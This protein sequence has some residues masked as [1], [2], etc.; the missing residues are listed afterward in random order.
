MNKSNKGGAK[1]TTTSA[2]K[3]PT[4]NNE[5][6]K[7][8]KGSGVPSEGNKTTTQN[9]NEKR[10]CA[11]VQA[12]YK[13]T[14][15]KA[16]PNK[17]SINNK[18]NKSNGNGGK[19]PAKKSKKKVDKLDL[20]L[21]EFKSQ[22][23]EKE[24]APN[25][26]CAG[27]DEAEQVPTEEKNKIDFDE[28]EI[29]VIKKN[30]TLKEH[31]ME[32]Q[33]NSHIRLLKNWPQVEMSIQTN[34]PTVPIEMVYQGKDYPIGEIQNYKHVLSGK[35]LQ[36]KKELEK[37]SLDYYEDLR[38][39]A[40]CHRQVRKYIQAYVQPGRKM[41]DI[42][43]ETEKKTKELILSHKLNCGWGFPTGCSLNH[44][45]AHYTPNYGDETVLK[46]DDVCKLD[47]GVH[48]NGY[49]IDCAFTIAF[50]EKYDNLIKATQDGTNTGIREA[51]I[52]ARMCDI[53]E[54]IQEAIESYEIELNKKI[55]PIKA[56]SN[57]RGHSIN[58]YIIHGGKCVPIVKQK[59]ENEIMEE[60]ELF[61][62][63]TFA[64]TGKGYVTHGNECSHYMR[65]P[66][67]Q[68]VPIRLN[69]AKTLLKVI[70][71]N[72]DTLPF[73]HRWLDD[74]GQ[75]R[76]FMALK[77]LVDLNIVEPYPPLCD[78]KNSFTSQMEHTILLRPT[79]KEVLSRGPDF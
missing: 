64:S 55:Y 32:E 62:I 67:K 52:D 19:T 69:S 78:V 44:C 75:K 46:Y 4:Q 5:K 54:A 76:H 22:V 56:I 33:N 1:G 3:K 38:K 6:S 11:D 39:A 26:Q 47:F 57:L 37:I 59:E 24:P 51:G 65:N 23:N 74:L 34:P 9:E 60:G 70:N 21:N 15:N 30:I 42:V 29:E 73:C 45:A 8:G 13:E 12:V 7:G 72:F 63:E 17:A 68:F 49:I 10:E 77:T 41:I 61:A 48:V 16:A 50:N 20:I 27:E 18:A 35:T 53:G 31:L 28:F 25:G 71:D 36:E 40:E 14:A 66:D 2:K 43:K 79:C 58:K